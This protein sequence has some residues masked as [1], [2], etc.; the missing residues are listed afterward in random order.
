MDQ[1]ETL[2]S[3]AGGVAVGTFRCP[4]S[5]ERFGGGFTDQ[6]LAVFPRTAVVIERERVP[7]VIADPNTVVFYNAGEHYVRT[8]IDRR[9]DHCD[10]FALTPTLALEVAS[11]VGNA[12][13]FR[14]GHGPAPAN[15]YLAQ[16]TV[17]TALA[18]R[19]ETDPVGVEEAV[20]A[21]FAKAVEHASVVDGAVA[22]NEHTVG[23]HRELVHEARRVLAERATERVSLTDV[24]A[25]VAASPFH[26]ARIFRRHTGFTVHA[27][28]TQLRLRTSLDYVTA[29]DVDL[30]TLAVELGFSSHSHFTSSFRRAFGA[31][32]S[33][34]RKASAARMSDLR[35]ILTV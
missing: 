8:G 6:H 22:P 19:G 17:V 25:H 7:P 4:P 5:H 34:F 13:G 20:L 21:I 14:F 26:L 23:R 29:P 12:E 2:L 27:F 11:A 15:L 32:P 31:P 10:F 1:V 16:R 9:G 30:A 24:A 28:L 18:R 35:K 33:R 3:R